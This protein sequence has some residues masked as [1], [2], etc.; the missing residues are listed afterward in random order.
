MLTYCLVYIT[1]KNFVLMTSSIEI[2]FISMS[3]FG[4]GIDLRDEEKS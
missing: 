3:T 4:R 1:P 2:S